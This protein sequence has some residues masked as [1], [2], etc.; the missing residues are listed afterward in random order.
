MAASAIWLKKGLGTKGLW[1]LL[2]LLRKAVEARSVEG[3]VLDRGLERP[4]CEAVKM[5]PGLCFPPNVV[6]YPLHKD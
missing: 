4:L 1:N 6:S 2:L 5:K 3:E